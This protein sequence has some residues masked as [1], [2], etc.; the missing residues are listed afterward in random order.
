MSAELASPAP[1]SVL[2]NGGRKDLHQLCGA[3]SEAHTRDDLGHGELKPVAR[4][5][6]GP[7]DERHEPDLPVAE[8]RPQHPPRELAARRLAGPA[9]VLHLEPPHAVLALLLGQPPAGPLRRV[10]HEDQHNEADQHSGDAFGQEDPSASHL[11]RSSPAG[12]GGKQ[13]ETKR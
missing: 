4:D 7:E 2:M 5:R 10:D 1:G 6:V 13:R 3:G 8:H 9:T 11:E 12:E